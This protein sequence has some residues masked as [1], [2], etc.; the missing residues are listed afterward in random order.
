[1]I[2]V[3]ILVYLY[4]GMVVTWYVIEKTN[5]AYSLP[6]YLSMFPAWPFWLVFLL[7]KRMRNG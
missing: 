5:A 7:L 6:L 1:M 4:Y 2:V 3:L